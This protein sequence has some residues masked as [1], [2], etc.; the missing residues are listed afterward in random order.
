M[1]LKD[2]KKRIPSNWNSIS[3]EQYIELRELEFNFLGSLFDKEIDTL[4]ILTDEDIDRL[5]DL[6]ARSLY[7]LKKSIDFISKEPHTKYQPK[8]GEY[9]YKGVNELTLAEFIDLDTFYANNPIANIKT[10][11]SILY[12][13]ESTN[14]WG[15]K[16]IEPYEYNPADRESIFNEL[17]ITDIYGVVKDFISFREQF[18][19]DYENLMQPDFSDLGEEEVTEENKEE[20]EQEEIMNRYSWER[21]LYT[22]ANEDI[23]K[24]ED[25]LKMNL[26]FVFNMLSM[27]AELKI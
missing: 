24:I 12:R 23:T 27:K 3:V 18:L 20:I 13:K 26:I 15:G 6:P 25:V 10:I 19:K 16:E 4:A 1:Y 22:V 2:L 8:I 14:K 7:D 11:C 5:E 21:L 17:P 9:I